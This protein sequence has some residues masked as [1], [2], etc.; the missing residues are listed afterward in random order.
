MSDTG[1]SAE[2]TE[3]EDTAQPGNG[4]PPTREQEPEPLAQEPG[5][6]A[7]AMPS[8]Q[9][10]LMRA[11]RWGAVTTAVLLVVCGGIGW[12]V[13]GSPGLVGGVLGAAFAGLFLGLTVG[14]IAFA[15]RFIGDP[16]Y[17]VI[18]FAI[19]VGGWVLKFVAF[20]VAAV[21]LRDQ[22]WLEPKVLFFSLVA[23]VI[24][25]LGMDVFVM[26]KSRLPYI[27]DPAV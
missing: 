17:V 3:P 13:A 25:S 24:V 4:E 11:L 14:S 8:S 27:S 16:T 26:L 7:V 5:P 20:I 22:A 10:V 12:W 18:F 19:V 2:G 6:Q 9:P 23:G 21:L 15:N 1:L